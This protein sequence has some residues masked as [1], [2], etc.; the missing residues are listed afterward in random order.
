MSGRNDPIPIGQSDPLLADTRTPARP[1]PWRKRPAA[2]DY[3][4]K[5]DIKR[6]DCRSEDSKTNGISD[7]VTSSDPSV[8]DDRGQC[9]PASATNVNNQPKPDINTCN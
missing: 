7:V 8:N 9:C 4:D 5:I 3:F 2:E 6:V 1:A